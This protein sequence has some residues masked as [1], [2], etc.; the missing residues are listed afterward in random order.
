MSTCIIFGGAGY[1]G[2]H[3]ANFLLDKNIFSTVHI[4]DIRESSLNGHKGIRTTL[5]DVRKSINLPYE[6]GTVDWIFNFAAVHREPGHKPMEYYETNICGAKNVC[7]FAEKILCN[8]IFFTASI[9]VYGPTLT[10]TAEDSMTTP[11][12]PYGISKLIAESTHQMWALNGNQRR[13]V[14][15]RPGVIYGPNDPGNILRM[16][17]AIKR[18]YFF[19]PTSPS[20]HKSYG[21]IYGLLESIW[22]MMNEKEKIIIYNYVEKE[23]EPIGEMIKIVNETL[24]YNGRTIRIP[25]WILHLT[26]SIIYRISPRFNGIHPDR[27]KKVARPTHILPNVLIKKGFV[28]KYN[29]R[30]SLLHWKNLSSS[31]F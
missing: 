11:N 26:A 28:F 23:T 17:K 25:F 1:I 29:F 22:F 10:P 15:V 20:I 19:L 14:S 2:T 8:N 9:S 5:T 18:G 12:T 31:D 27:V 21:Y 6:A 16:I 30:D 13:L 24:K 3:L 7:D 4:A